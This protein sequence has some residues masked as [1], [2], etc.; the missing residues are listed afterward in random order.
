MHSLGFSNG[1]VSRPLQPIPVE[2]RVHSGPSP[3]SSNTRRASSSQLSSP[4]VP[5]P[6][7]VD[8]T[9]SLGCKRK[10]GQK[11]LPSSVP[12]YNAM[13]QEGPSPH[14]PQPQVVN[15]PSSSGSVLFTH[16]SMD[17]REGSPT[18]TGSAGG[19]YANQNV[20]SLAFMEGPLPSEVRDIIRRCCSGGK[21]EDAERE[22]RR[23]LSTS[24]RVKVYRE[25]MTAA[26][27]EL[28]D[29]KV[30]HDRQCLVSSALR[31]EISEIDH[32]IEMLKKE[33]EICERQ[34]Q[35]CNGIESHRQQKLS[36]AQERVSILGSTIDN[37]ERESHMGHLMLRQMV[38]NLNIM[39]YV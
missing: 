6:R 23:L 27:E 11:P 25:E 13:M 28:A 5:Q 10:G 26:Q 32:R 33:R 14:Q 36:E 38:P 21:A 31:D 34:L 29:A 30:D 15:P 22:A 18:Q 16:H 24:R 8:S 1:L 39:N 20:S 7:P 9:S 12:N 19:G 17:G 4:K 35:D 3:S 2:S 37:I